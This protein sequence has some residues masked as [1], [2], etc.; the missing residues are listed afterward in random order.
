MGGVNFNSMTRS[1]GG[2]G[3]GR[4]RETS[5]QM[6][7]FMTAF[8]VILVQP[9]CPRDL[10]AKGIQFQSTCNLCRESHKT[11][12]WLRCFLVLSFLSTSPCSCA[13]LLNDTFEL[14]TTF[15]GLREAL[16]KSDAM[17]Y[18]PNEVTNEVE[19]SCKKMILKCYMLEL[20]MVINEEDILDDNLDVF[21]E[22][23]EHHLKEPKSDGCRQCETYP[24]VNITTF[25]D[26]LNSLFQ[27]IQSDNSS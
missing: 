13:I 22:F 3:V 19:E 9:T 26:R 8:P 14:Q 10:R 15:E 21:Y 25:S 27:E 16:K 17:L 20:M 2:N 12:V 24:L 4:A 1:S 23:Y 6:I 5:A 18:A 11:Q 7:D